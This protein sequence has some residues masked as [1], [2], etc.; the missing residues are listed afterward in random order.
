MNPPKQDLT[1]RYKTCAARDCSN[2]AVY[3]MEI[4]YLGKTGWFCEHCKNNLIADGLLVQ[5]NLDPISKSAHSE[6]SN[7]IIEKRVGPSMVTSQPTRPPP[8]PEY[9]SVTIHQLRHNEGAVRYD[10]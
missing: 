4:L 3:C 1:Q 9:Q 10:Y 7:L 5:Q 8:E 6:Q 2:H